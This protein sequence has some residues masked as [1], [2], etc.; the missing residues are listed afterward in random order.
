[1]NA[2]LIADALG[3]GIYEIPNSDRYIILLPRELLVP[4]GDVWKTLVATPP[5]FHICIQAFSVLHLP[6]IN[7]D[8][9]VP[10]EALRQFREK[11]TFH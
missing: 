7:Q 6:R 1:M 9:I 2:L 11:V 5:S 8:S 4:P 10:R 3:T